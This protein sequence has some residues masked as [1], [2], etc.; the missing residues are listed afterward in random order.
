LPSGT[1]ASETILCP[2]SPRISSRIPPD[3]RLHRC[4][5]PQHDRRGRLPE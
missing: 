4:P 1:A 3:R 5:F 2:G